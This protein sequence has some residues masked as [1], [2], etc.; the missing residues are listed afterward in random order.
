VIFIGFLII[1]DPILFPRP[2]ILS[3][4][5]F[6]IV[7]LLF[8]WSLV[9]VYSV[10]NQ[11]VF[12]SVG[13]QLCLRFCSSD[14]SL[15]RWRLQKENMQAAP[16]KGHLRRSRRQFID[17]MNHDGFNLSRPNWSTADRGPTA[18]Y[19]P[20]PVYRRSLKT[21]SPSATLM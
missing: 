17:E 14:G 15:F 12:L 10:K 8:F 16:K 4:P 11:T 13:L 5:N 3:R 7:L 18:P 6:G 1:R 2:F 20:G 21:L 19:R 9:L